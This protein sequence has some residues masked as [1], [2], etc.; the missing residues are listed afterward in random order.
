MNVK[1]LSLRLSRTLMYSK[2]LIPGACAFG[3]I[4][5]WRPETKK[6]FLYDF[7]CIDRTQLALTFM[8]HN[9]HLS[10]VVTC[11]LAL[12][13]S[14]PVPTFRAFDST[15]ITPPKAIDEPVNGPISTMMSECSILLDEK[16]I[17]LADKRT[18]PGTVTID[19]RS[20]TK[21]DLNDIQ[22]FHS[23]LEVDNLSFTSEGF[24]LRRLA[25]CIKHNSSFP[26]HKFGIS[27]TGVSPNQT[28]V[29]KRTI[30]HS[31]E[32][33]THLLSKQRDSRDFFHMIKHEFSGR[34]GGPANDPL[35]SIIHMDAYN[36]KSVH[37]IKLKK[38]EELQLQKAL[39]AAKAKQKEI[40]SRKI[41]AA[42]RILKNKLSGTKEKMKECLVGEYSSADEEKDNLLLVDRKVDDEVKKSQWGSLLGPIGVS[43]IDLN[44]CKV[45]SYDE[46]EFYR[47]TTNQVRTIGIVSIPSATTYSIDDAKFQT[48]AQTELIEDLLE[49]R[50]RLSDQIV[51]GQRYKDILLNSD[52]Q[53]ALEHI[54]KVPLDAP[55]EALVP[56]EIQTKDDVPPKVSNDSNMTNE[57]KVIQATRHADYEVLEQMLDDCGVDI[58]SADEYGN[59]LLIISGQQGN[60]KLCKFLLRRGAYINAQNHAGNTILHYLHEY[61]HVGL[62]DY[63]IR[64]GADDTYLNAEGLTC[65]EGLN[66]N[67][68]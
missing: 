6:E 26:L 61:A 8:P 44:K 14:L 48:S 46:N 9:I 37:G 25:H 10:P 68:L 21:K 66:I 59:T 54:L 58:D 62:A 13:T 11:R 41:E 67:N 34:N 33:C 15:S 52:Q 31:E 30:W 40:I 2:S 43:L 47:C 55:N 57:E 12:E 53:Y 23:C 24:R 32:R 28:G 16:L 42:D 36:L 20:L 65:Y 63:M 3:N 56:L 49:D 4:G 7:D 45:G 29:N 50:F 38:Q 39:D 27:R 64:K 60:K 17:S 1:P 5:S 19:G 35:I 51:K 22:S 18:L